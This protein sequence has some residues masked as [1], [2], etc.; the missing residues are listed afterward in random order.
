MSIPLAAFDKDV[1]RAIHD[2]ITTHGVR[3]RQPDGQHMLLYSGS[4]GE[5]P[6]KVAA[7]RKPEDSLKF[8]R[9][10]A[11]KHGFTEQP[12]DTPTAQVPEET[13]VAPA[14]TAKTSPPSFLP[15]VI[16]GQ[17]SEYLISD[18]TTIRCLKCPW[19]TTITRGAHLHIGTHTGQTS[20]AAK[21][22]AA[23]R[24]KN[25]EKV[26]VR[27]ALQVLAE[28]HGLTV[29]DDRTAEVEALRQQV[30][31]LKTKLAL[32]KEAMSL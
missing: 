31:D 16:K 12:A 28:E 20:E 9:Q 6:L 18:G 1:R 3:Y 23:S 14:H 30:A 19:E 2:L 27:K 21:L 26:K 5:R 29:G 25:L 22:A 7:A 8:I 32:I 24:R 10:W 11:D 13:T 4:R 15:Y 17:P